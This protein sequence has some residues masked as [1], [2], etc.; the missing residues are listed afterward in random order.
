[1]IV[2]VDILI[3]LKN[4][5][6][7]QLYI[8]VLRVKLRY[9][10]QLKSFIKY[11]YRLVF[12]TNQVSLKEKRILHFENKIFIEKPCLFA[13]LLFLKLYFVLYINLKKFNHGIGCKRE[14]LGF[15]FY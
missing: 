3:P 1:M 5:N 2:N 15:Y 8:K 10:C 7:I 14:H 13:L 9:I 4:K 11:K 6:I 12:P